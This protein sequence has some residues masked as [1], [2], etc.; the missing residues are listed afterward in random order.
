[1]SRRCSSPR[2]RTKSAPAKPCSFSARSAHARR[3]RHRDLRRR[4]ASRRRTPRWAR[5]E[6]QPRS[7]RA[8]AS[9]RAERRRGGAGYPRAVPGHGFQCTRQQRPVDSRPANV[10]YDCAIGSAAHRAADV[11]RAGRYRAEARYGDRIT[12]QAYPREK[13]GQ[14]PARVLSIS[15]TPTLPGD[16][17]E[18]VPVSEPSFVAVAMLPPR[19]AGPIGEALW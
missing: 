13:F 10:L 16:D 2:S 17:A 12:L 5:R 4:K 15:D 7:G 3:A 14:F 1:M 11:A 6:S 9:R 18:I 8:G 19:L